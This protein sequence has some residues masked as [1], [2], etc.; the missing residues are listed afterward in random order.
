VGKKVKSTNNMNKKEGGGG[1]MMGKYVH[2]L[3]EK[4]STGQTEQ[5]KVNI[6][7]TQGQGK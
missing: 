4:L 6:D 2:V 5:K 1:V 7:S 3:V